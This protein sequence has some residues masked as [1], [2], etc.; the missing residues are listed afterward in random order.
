MPKI[1]GPPGI[2]GQKSGTQRTQKSHRGA[3]R[4]ALVTEASEI[5]GKRGNKHGRPLRKRGLHPGGAWAA[6]FWDATLAPP[7]SLPAKPEAAFGGPTWRTPR[8]L[9]RPLWITAS[10]VTS[11]NPGKAGTRGGTHPW[12]FSV[13][14]APLCALCVPAFPEKPEDQKKRAPLG[15]ARFFGGNSWIRSG[16]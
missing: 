10:S 1:K 9:P 15:R 7:G 8:T 6:F 14:S 11:R 3:Q 5:R 12:Q 4:K 2:Q 16:T 13:A